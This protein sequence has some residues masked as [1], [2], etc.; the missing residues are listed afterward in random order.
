[1]LGLILTRFHVTLTRSYNILRDWREC[2]NPSPSVLSNR[3]RSHKFWHLNALPILI[4]R[5]LI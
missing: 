5:L 3:E 2:S 4:L 1:M